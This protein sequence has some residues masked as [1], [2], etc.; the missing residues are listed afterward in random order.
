MDGNL[1]FQME[2]YYNEDHHETP[3]LIKKE[4]FEINKAKRSIKDENNR[5]SFELPNFNRGAKLD[6]EALANYINNTFS[7]SS[8]NNKLIKTGRQRKKS[9]ARSK[10][11][12]FQAL[13]KKRRLYFCSI[14]SEINVED[15]YDE[16]N[17]KL[18]KVD[19]KF[20]EMKAFLYDEVLH[21]YFD[22]HISLVDHDVEESKF[23]ED[24]I[25][26]HPEDPITEEDGYQSSSMKIRRRYSYDDALPS[27]P[28]D[29]HSGSNSPMI[30]DNKK[31]LL[32]SLDHYEVNHTDT[33]IDPSNHHDNYLL[34]DPNEE[35]FLESHIYNPLTK[36][37]VEA[38]DQIKILREIFIF[39]FGAMVFWGFTDEEEDELI[40]LFRKYMLKPAFTD[41]EIKA[42]EDDMAYLISDDPESHSADIAISNDVVIIPY[43][44]YQVKNRLAVSFAFAQSSILSIFE[45]RIEDMIEEYKTIPEQLALSGKVQLSQKQLGNMIGQIFVIRHEVNLQSEILDI[46]DYFWKEHAIEPIYKMTLLY[47]EMEQRTEVLNKRLDLMHELLQLLQHQNENEHN[48]KLEWIVIWLIVVSVLLEL[49]SFLSEYFF[50]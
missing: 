24:H 33:E 44:S 45:A 18:L 16:Y 13:R 27:K 5:A 50:K 30:I 22:E 32:D 21:I 34:E 25:D 20:G 11:S 29:W 1:Q 7:K 17:D 39:D 48:I 37:I 38:R 10:G 6:N 41:N 47:L 40:L 9:A 42:G 26:S 14:S 2:G 12:D 31:P 3:L 36:R 8:L 35:K 19:P 49:F 28:Q 43:E 23:H 46:P 15:L 4:P